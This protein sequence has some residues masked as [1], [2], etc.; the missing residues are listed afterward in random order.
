M[1]RVLLAVT[2][3]LALMGAVV[4]RE[5]WAAPEARRWVCA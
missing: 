5:A 3:C 4:A 1:K 2:A